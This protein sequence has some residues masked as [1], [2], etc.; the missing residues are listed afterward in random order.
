[1]L[2]S[3]RYHTDNIWRVAQA[4]EM[5]EE[6][7]RRGN[8]PFKDVETLMRA[9]LG[10]HASSKDVKKLNPLEVSEWIREQFRVG[11]FEVTVIGDFERHTLLNQ[12]EEWIGTIPFDVEYRGIGYDIHEV[13][14]LPKRELWGP[15]EGITFN[16]VDFEGMN[17][18]IDICESSSYAEDRA[19]VGAIIPAP[20]VSSVGGVSS[21][22]KMDSVMRAVL[23][24][25]L[26]IDNGFTYYVVVDPLIS[27]L[28]P[29]EAY[30]ALFWGPG[31]YP[32]ST[33]PK[34]DSLNVLASFKKCVQFIR[35][36]KF[37]ER[38]VTGAEHMLSSALKSVEKSHEMWLMALEGLSLRTPLWV[39]G[40]EFARSYN[41]LETSP[42]PQSVIES[43]VKEAA[44]SKKAH[45][46]AIQTAPLSER[47]SCLPF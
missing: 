47:K 2:T 42:L 26:R 36:G 16:A 5:E 29:D 43:F 14:E 46:I 25:S 33:T 1:M 44:N 15:L 22:L 34:E 12:L 3:P 8:N 7:I 17:A 32:K 30:Y 6:D 10:V 23:M 4:M 39:E 35:E 45:G 19:F 13:K 11:F 18:D 41:D 20:P 31:P 27:F 9:R 21:R 38:S 28:H 24:D 37:D 40:R